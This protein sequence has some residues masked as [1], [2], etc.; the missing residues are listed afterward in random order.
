MRLVYNSILLVSLFFFSCKKE[1][2][3]IEVTQPTTA[4]S[5]SQNVEYANGFSIL[6]YTTHKEITVTSPW[7]EANK[8]FTYI[9]YPRGN[10]K[11]KT[12]HPDALYIETPINSIVVTST[13]DV[14]IL[15]HLGLEN[16]LVGFPNTDY[17]SSIK[18]RKLIDNG[19]IKELGKEYN[20][21]TEVILDLSPDLIVG[22]SSNN[23]TNAYDLIQKS[24]IPVVMNGSWMEKHPL[25][26][27]EWIK[28][29]AAFF[30]EEAKAERIFQV[31]KKSYTTAT[32]IAHTTKTTPKVMS[33]S[34]YKDVWHVPG[35]DSFIAQLLKDAKT[36]YLW[37]DVK[38]KG[39]IT[40]NFENVLDRAQNADF[41]IGAGDSSS[42]DELINLNHQYSIFDAFKNK[43]VYSSTLKIGPKGGLLYYEI[44]P[45]RP[46]IILKDLIKI[47]HPEL[48]NDYKPY[49]FKKLN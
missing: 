49:F 40:L 7:P 35:G 28:F 17:V 44:G 15:E 11:P 36:Y 21:N 4:S 9:L 30:N 19:C 33:G 29:I 8:E 42:L 14:P 5:A 1:N 45:M 43:T 37:E 25:G 3:K 31:I 18:T 23:D 26:R 16:T 13:T 27:T 10:D 24:G 47:T 12:N 6:T 20:L 46:D 38:Q 34:L 48:L 22:F 39:S 2:D 32:K 41:W